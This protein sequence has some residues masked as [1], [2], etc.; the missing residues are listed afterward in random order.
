MIALQ[1]FCAPSQATVV[2]QLVDA[3]LTAQA[4]SVYVASDEPDTAAKLSHALH[5]RPSLAGRRCVVND[6]ARRCMHCSV[7]VV[8][9]GDMLQD[10]LAIRAATLFIGNCISSFTSFAARD[11]ANAARPT[12][13]WGLAD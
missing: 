7:R 6:P 13:Y 1:S 2:T 11:R 10:L 9:G 12:A 4:F 8:P 5:A 3:M